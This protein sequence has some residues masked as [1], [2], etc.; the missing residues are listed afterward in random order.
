MDDEDFQRQ[1]ELEAAEAKAK[2]AA[3]AGNQSSN[4]YLYTDATGTVFE[5]DHEKRAWFPKIDD[6]FLALYQASY[7]FANNEPSSQTK[8]EVTGTKTNEKV[9]QESKPENASGNHSVDSK[10]STSSSNEN[11]SNQETEEEADTDKKQG[12]KRRLE[13]PASWFEVDDDHNT[14][15][16]VS[17]LPTDISE[18]DFVTFMSKCGFIM[19]DPETNKFKVKLY[20]DNTGE[21]KGD[22]L[23]TYIKVESVDLALQLLDE[24]DFKGK[25]I[26]VERAKFTLKGEYDP[27]KRPKRKK[28]DKKKMQ[29]KLDKLFDWRPDKIV[30]E[31]PKCQQ[32]II[33]K[34]MFDINDFAKDPKLILEYRNDLREEC[35]EKCGPVKKVEIFDNN[36][37]GVASVCFTD[38]NHADACLS[39]MNGRFFAG[40]KL[41]AESWDGKT[42]YR[43]NETEEQVEKRMKEWDKFL[44]ST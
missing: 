6:N 42:K 20:R 7:G 15:V 33:I 4:P 27:N 31:R 43:V 37:E 30:T 36:P 10:P 44:D 8:D 18:E 12:K 29:K 21:L 39:L 38:F 5:W 2:E 13:Q 14:N 9:A 17:N 3:A 11:N 26:K 32:T 24:S 23:C 35:S 19:K 28:G 1:L 34:N 25:K 22:A 41:T 16:Y 40:R